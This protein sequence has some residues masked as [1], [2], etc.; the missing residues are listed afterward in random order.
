MAPAAGFYA[1]YFLEM[2]TSSVGSL[3]L[4]ANEH[5]TQR[6]NGSLIPPAGGVTR[7]DASRRVTL[8]PASDSCA[9][10]LSHQIRV[11]RLSCVSSPSIPLEPAIRF[12]RI[13]RDAG[14]CP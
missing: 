11:S 14:A 1:F 3:R 6:L 9:S 8:F 10:G 2:I 5:V 7:A 12:S 13:R 4:R